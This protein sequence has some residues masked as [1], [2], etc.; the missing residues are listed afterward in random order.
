MHRTTGKLHDLGSHQW[1]L[2]TRSQRIAKSIPSRL[3]ITMFG[4]QPGDQPRVAEPE[5]SA[6]HDQSEISPNPA[7]EPATRVRADSLPSVK[8]P[9]VCEGWAPPPTP[10]HGPNYRNLSPQEKQ[11]LAQLH[12]N[13][14]HPDPNVL[15]SHLQAQGG[16]EAVVKGARDFVCDSCV[17]GQKPFHQRPAKLRQPQ[18]FNE[19]IGIDGIYWSGKGNFQVYIIHIYDESTGFHLARRLDGHNLDHV[20]PAFQELWT[21]WA[22]NPSGMYLDPAGEFRADQWLDFLQSMNTLP[23]MTV[24]AWQRGRIERHGAILKDMLHRMDADRTLQNVSQ[25]DEALRLC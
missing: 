15:A 11:E 8:L 18:E 23:F 25:V 9:E 20:I 21:V 7:A 10:L 6:N 4:N 5:G 24:E 2:L 22:G 3:T 12:R 13:L 1:H 17:E 14:G 19:L 16:S